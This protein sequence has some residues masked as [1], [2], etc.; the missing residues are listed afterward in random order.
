MTALIGRDSLQVAHFD[1]DTT[2]QMG[3]SSILLGPARRLHHAI[4]GERPAM[5][6][7][8]MLEGDFFPVRFPFNPAPDMLTGLFRHLLGY[9]LGTVVNLLALLAILRWPVLL[10]VVGVWLFLFNSD[11]LV[12]NL[13][14]PLAPDPS[15][16]VN[17][18]WA[19]PIIAL[20]ATWKQLGF[21]VLLYLAALQNIP[22][23]LYEAAEMDGITGM[24]PHIKSGRLRLLAAA[25]AEPPHTPRGCP[26]QAW[27]GGEAWPI[28]IYM[29][30]LTIITIVSVYLSTETF[31]KDISE[32]QPGEGVSGVARE[33]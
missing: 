16:L 11:G 33:A 25:H 24:T 1:G 22:E 5:R 30:A 21:Y 8:P 29:I 7:W 15:W 10:A 31:Q 4:H 13:L 14:G 28:A 17:S 27:S 26:F 20:F 23:E 32:E 18:F 6:G 19:M 2:L 9:R 3:G 12:N